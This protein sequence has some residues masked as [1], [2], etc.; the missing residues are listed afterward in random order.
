MILDSAVTF[1]FFPVTSQQLEK[2]LN[3]RH[4]TL[5][6]VSPKKEKETNPHAGLRPSKIYGN[7]HGKGPFKLVFSYDT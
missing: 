3:Y 5:S 6:H 1:Q 2:A 7:R 4:G